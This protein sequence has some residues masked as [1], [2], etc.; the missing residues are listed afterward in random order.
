MVKKAT[1]ALKIVHDKYAKNQ[2]EMVRV[3]VTALR[4][5]LSLA[6]RAAVHPTRRHNTAARAPLR[7]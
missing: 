7:R 3:R 1:Q 5:L 6:S 2:L 4:L